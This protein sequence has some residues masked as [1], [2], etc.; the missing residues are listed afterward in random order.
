MGIP[1][2]RINRQLPGRQQVGPPHEPRKIWVHAELKGLGLPQ[3]T[4]PLMLS[5]N[6]SLKRENFPV[7]EDITGCFSVTIKRVMD[8]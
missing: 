6:S 3:L 4:I 8:G 7:L 2:A 5:V 1:S